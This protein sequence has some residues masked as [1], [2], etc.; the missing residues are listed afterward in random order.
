MASMLTGPIGAA[1]A[2]PMKN[3]AASTWMSETNTMLRQIGKI[4]P[5]FH[6]GI[7]AVKNIHPIASN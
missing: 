5:K 4:S 1:D 6:A 3:A 7:L 2:N